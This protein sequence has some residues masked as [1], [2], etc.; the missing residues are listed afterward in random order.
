MTFDAG[1]TWKAVREKWEKNKELVIN[2]MG[3]ETYRHVYFY[4]SG[5]SAGMMSRRLGMYQVAFVHKRKAGM[6]V[7]IPRDFERSE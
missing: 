1:L 4:L 3:L 5:A 7:V 6:K 2:G